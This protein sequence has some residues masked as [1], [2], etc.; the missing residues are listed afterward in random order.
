MVIVRWTQFEQNWRLTQQPEVNANF[1]DILFAFLIISHAK[2]KS[3]VNKAEF[4]IPKKDRPQIGLCKIVDLFDRKS[5]QFI[6]D[7]DG[8]SNISDHW[9]DI[10]RIFGC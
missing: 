3:D 5:V 9:N 7:F 4:L 8:L 6:T 2:N 10:N 1:Q